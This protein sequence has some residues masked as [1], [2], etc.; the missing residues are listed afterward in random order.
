M[1]LSVGLGRIINDP[2]ATL[3]TRKALG[4]LSEPGLL[5]YDKGLTIDNTGRITLRINPD[6]GI[7]ED[8]NGLK[9]SPVEEKIGIDSFVDPR[10]EK[11][12]RDWNARLTGPAPNYFEGSLAIG[13]EEFGGNSAGIEALGLTVE[14]AKVNITATQ[15]QLRLSYDTRNFLS[16]RVL[17]TGFVEQFSIGVED[18]GF[19][20][21]SGDGTQSGIAGGFK[22]NYGTT[23][24]QIFSVKA[25]INL[26]GGGTAGTMTN[27]EFL[28]SVPTGY[29]VRNGQDHV[30]VCPLGGATVPAEW[31]GWTARIHSTNQLLLR[32]NWL[33]VTGP[34]ARDW[35]FMV[36]KLKA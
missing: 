32:I 22:I 7:I 36:H 19:H 31:V 33:D 13:T 2:K 17:S 4:A 1:T 18:P 30:S 27:E 16:T 9:L 34:E 10:S 15:T 5:V 35:L 8:E 6:G 20:F 24:E 23:I 3:L 14:D 28:V 11:Y 21:I 26:S 12:D 29:S 25:T